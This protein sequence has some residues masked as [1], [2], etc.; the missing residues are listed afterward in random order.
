MEFRRIV[1]DLGDTGRAFSSPP[2]LPPSLRLVSPMFT[3]FNVR[4]GP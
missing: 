3:E 1:A 4:R 2:S